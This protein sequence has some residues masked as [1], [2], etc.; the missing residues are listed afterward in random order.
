MVCLQPPQA[1]LQHLRRQRCVAP[2]SADLGHQKDLVPKAFDSLPQPVFRF[3]TVVFPAAVEECD[4]A[5]D[6]A[7]DDLYCGLLIFR[8]AKMMAAQA[9]GGNLYAGL[10]EAL[11]RNQGCACHTRL[12]VMQAAHCEK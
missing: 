8:G 3:A 11:Q 4:A 5:V 12:S 10:A 6:R 7:V 9:H 2:V 1:L